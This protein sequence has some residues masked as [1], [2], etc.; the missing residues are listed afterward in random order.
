MSGD[1]ALRVL[2]AGVL[3]RA[4]MRAFAGAL[5]SRG[6]P[7]PRPEEKMALHRLVEER[8]WSLPDD[9]AALVEGR[10]VDDGVEGLPALEAEA[11]RLADEGVAARGS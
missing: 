6:L 4:T 10:D 7:P 5:A 2:L 3:Y 9:V 1:P 8:A 11:A